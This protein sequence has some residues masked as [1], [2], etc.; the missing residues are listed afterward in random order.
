MV[1]FGSFRVDLASGVVLRDDAEDTGHQAAGLTQD[2]GLLD[3]G[4]R[5]IIIKA[6]SENDW[7]FTQTAQ[8][9]GIGRTTLWRKVKK[10]NLTRETVEQ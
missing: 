2:V 6:L 4:Q 9:L 5:S 8:E 7:N 10:Y 3:E 1:A